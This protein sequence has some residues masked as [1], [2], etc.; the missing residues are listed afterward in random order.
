MFDI[1]QTDDFRKWF[2]KLKDRKARN[3]LLERINRMKFAHWGDVKPVGEGVRELRV[4]YGP[5]F[6]VYF[7][8]MG[9]TVIVL[10]CGGTKGSQDKDIQK[11][12]QLARI[13][14]E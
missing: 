4:H 12:K 6:R 9:E 10:L 8:Q 1:Q 13:L 14:K 11:A 5:G 2:K 7:V 3:I